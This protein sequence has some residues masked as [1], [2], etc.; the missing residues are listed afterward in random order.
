MT[1]SPTFGLCGG[2]LAA[3]DLR[4]AATPIDCVSWAAA[5]PVA[6]VP[7]P[8]SE[9]AK[10][11]LHVEK[12]PFVGVR[13]APGQPEVN[14]WTGSNNA[15]VAM[16]EDEAPRT[17]H[18]PQRAGHVSHQMR[19]QGAHEGRVPIVEVGV[20]ICRDAP[21]DRSQ[22]TLMWI[23]GMSSTPTIPT[24]A[25]NFLPCSGL[26]VLRRTRKYPR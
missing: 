11:I 23:S 26:D 22:L 4:T 18:H 7:S 9:A 3:A 24:T 14:A 12:V 8:W 21:G 13:M 10:G 17:Q 25:E 19:P 6:G 1:A 15:P 20:R 2:S 5:T 16:Y